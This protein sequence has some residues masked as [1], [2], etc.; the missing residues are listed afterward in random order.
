MVKSLQQ[1][2]QLITFPLNQKALSWRVLRIYVDDDSEKK[3]SY[4]LQ[5]ADSV[6]AHCSVCESCHN[7]ASQSIR[8]RLLNTWIPPP[9]NPIVILLCGIIEVVSV[10]YR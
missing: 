4:I 2:I 3:S 1:A 10:R 5:S 6:A 7:R 8:D 9:S